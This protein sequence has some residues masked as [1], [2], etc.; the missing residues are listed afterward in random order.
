MKERQTDSAA[1]KN[2]DEENPKGVGITG[3]MSQEPRCL[4][5][6]AEG[7]KHSI[8]MDKSTDESN[9]LM[10]E[11]THGAPDHE[12][13]NNSSRPGEFWAHPTTISIMGEKGDGGRRRR[14]LDNKIPPVSKGNDTAR[15]PDDDNTMPGLGPGQEGIR[16]IGRGTYFCSREDVENGG[17]MRLGCLQMQTGLHRLQREPKE[18]LKKRP[19]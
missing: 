12:S 11:G 15:G 3:F 18:R 19:A 17:M 8:G 9:R 14:E 1:R 2:V 6:W 5:L 4:C 16:R 13:S 10:S 7:S